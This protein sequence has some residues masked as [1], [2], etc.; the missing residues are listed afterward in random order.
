MQVLNRS[1]HFG[2]VDTYSALEL[3]KA[4]DAAHVFRRAGTFA[5]Q[6]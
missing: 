6:A 3:G 1:A 4:L 5:L 2:E